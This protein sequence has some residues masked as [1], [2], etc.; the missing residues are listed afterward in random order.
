MDIHNV[1][2][3][4]FDLDG[5]VYLGAEAIPG[6]HQFVSYL[7]SEQIS[8]S[9]LTNN[10]SKSGYDYHRK[11]LSLG[12]SIEQDRVFTSGQAAAQ[13]VARNHP[14]TPVYLLGTPSLAAEF[15]AA[16]VPVSEEAA[17]AVVIGCVTLFEE[18]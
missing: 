9:F 15:G 2:H 14:D 7:D 12:F 5:T 4:F 17:E 3:W 11:L 1:R 10:S 18:P 13:Y 16:Y 6:A 8:Y